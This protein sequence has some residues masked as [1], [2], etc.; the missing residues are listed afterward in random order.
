M[1]EMTW[2]GLFW[3]LYH[4]CLTK[5][6]RKRAE[7]I[8]KKTKKKENVRLF[9]CVWRSG[10]PSCRLVSLRG[11]EISLTGQPSHCD[12]SQ[13]GRVVGCDKY[14]FTASIG[15]VNGEPLTA[16][17]RSIGQKA[18]TSPPCHFFLCVCLLTGS[19]SHF[20]SEFLEHLSEFTPSLTESL[21]EGHVL[22]GT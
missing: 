13:E 14:P 11:Q 3:M 7:P 9:V 17:M 1:H 5:T 19:L 4:V 18:S 20:H 15:R 22:S 12:P 21:K 6:H 2:D 10:S 8:S 16:W